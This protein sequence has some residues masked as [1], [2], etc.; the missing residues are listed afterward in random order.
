[1]LRIEREF[2]AVIV[3][4]AIEESENFDCVF[5]FVAVFLF[6]AIRV[7]FWPKYAPQNRFPSKN[8]ILFHR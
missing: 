4:V 3:L 8:R 6:L 1:M 5:G 7:Y 2:F